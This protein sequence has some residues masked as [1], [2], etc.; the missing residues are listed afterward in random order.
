MLGRVRRTTRT[1]VTL[2][3]IMAGVVYL[4]WAGAC[5]IARGAAEVV[6][7]YT[8]AHEL[9][10]TVWAQRL[11]TTFGDA[12]SLSA[13]PPVLGPMWMCLSL[14]LVI[15][16][17]RQRRI[18]SWAWLAITFQ[19]LGAIGVGVWSA[20]AVQQTLAAAGTVDPAGVEAAAADGANTVW[21]VVAAVAIWLATLTW[22]VID[23]LRFSRLGP[24][25]GDG[26]RTHTF[27]R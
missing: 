4:A 12:S 14:W 5:A 24:S 15:R 2:A 23:R 10:P 26:I 1:D 18:I 7:Q 27:R 17:S 9:V 6:A 22:L 11:L 8:R 21:F 19:A 20:R 13:V 3:L 25:L 16:A